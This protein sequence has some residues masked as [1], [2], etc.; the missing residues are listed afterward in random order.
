MLRKHLSRNLWVLRL[1]CL[2]AVKP[3]VYQYHRQFRIRVCS[4]LPRS[5][6]TQRPSFLPQSNMGAAD[7]RGSHAD[8][9]PRRW[10]DRPEMWRWRWFVLVADHVAE[11]EKRRS[12]SHFR[13][14]P[15]FAPVNSYPPQTFS[16]GKSKRRLFI[17]PCLLY[18]AASVRPSESNVSAF[19]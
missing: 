6:E 2:R 19:T 5:V 11:T 15:H 3:T 10:T 16:F 17:G 13:A 12:L 14:S 9:L 18:G 4:L 7:S 1:E 8:A